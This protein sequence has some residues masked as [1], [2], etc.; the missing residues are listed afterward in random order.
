[1]IR[2]PGRL[3]R[4]D[5]RRTHA[6]AS[7]AALVLVAGCGDARGAAAE[8]ALA[9]SAA[10]HDWQ[11]RI[12]DREVTLPPEVRETSGAALDQ[13]A[14]GIFWT[15]GDS[16]RP[17]LLFALGVNGQLV[18]RVRLTGAHNRDWEDM[19]IGPCPSGQCVYVADIGDN[20]NNHHELVLYRAPLPLPS[21]VATR[22]AEVF[23]ARYPGGPRDAE[24]MFVT[25]QG[26][27]YLI[28]K[29]RQGAVGLWHWPT[30]L[31]PGPVD[32][33]HVR[34]VAPHPRQP[35]D[36]VTGAGS[37]QDGRWVAVRTYGRLA[38]YRTADLLGS[39]GPAFT[40]DL[41]PLGETQ[42]EG[43]AVESD[44]TVLLTSE[45]RA[46]TNPGRADWLQCS[47]PQS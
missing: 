5:V 10:A 2:L 4:M 17:P 35:G 38:L 19:A 20:R 31:V 22:P 39:G 25:Q 3:R 44:G 1:M 30:P 28:D 34:D 47:L 9:D 37:S 15:H 29:G 45:A 26:E 36:L 11:C 12:T 8:V 46:H 23:R 6:L 40:M 14:H 16:G 24:A 13:R 32:L 41:A 7:A 27:V 43:V 18:G 42:G 33:Q 21:D